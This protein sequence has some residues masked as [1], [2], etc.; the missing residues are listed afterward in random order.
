[1]IPK[2]DVRGK[3]KPFNI[4]NKGSIYPKISNYHAWWFEMGQKILP[5][6]NILT[7]GTTCMQLFTWRSGY[8]EM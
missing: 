8:H 5:L 1:M 4:N 2:P 6:N 3:S 7:S